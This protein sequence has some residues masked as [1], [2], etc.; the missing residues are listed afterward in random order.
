MKRFLR[1]LLAL[2]LVTAAL[3]IWIVWE[4][5]ALGVTRY[6]ITASTL[7]P[8]FAGYRIVQVSDL[9]NQTFGENNE[10]LLRL[11]REA[12]PDMIVMTGDLIDSVK[13]DLAVGLTFAEAAVAIAPTYFVTG[14]HEA[15]ISSRQFLRDL[16]ALGVTVLKDQRVTVTRGTD[17]ITL[18]G[19]QDPNFSREEDDVAART[20]LEAMM[21][22]EDGYTLLLAHRP[23]LFDVYVSC[24]VDLVLSG[25]AHGGQFRIPFVG[26]LFAPSQGWFPRYDNGIYTDGS[27]TMVVSRGI[28][29][30]RFPFRINNPPELVLVVLNPT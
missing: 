29:N 25:H 14:N 18:L 17:S 6:E 19:L 21:A 4:N 28:G 12:E 30:S 9:H 20:A 3:V 22:A 8:A 5:G 13:T 2:L 15:A 16:K 27:T 7:P 11:L 24:G 10:T 1:G 26:G 23:E